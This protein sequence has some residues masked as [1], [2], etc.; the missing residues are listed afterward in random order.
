MH[1]LKFDVILFNINYLGG[2][3]P[4]SIHIHHSRYKGLVNGIQIGVAT[5]LLFS[6]VILMVFCHQKIFRQK[7]LHL[8]EG[9]FLDGGKT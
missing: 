4:D 1:V 5:L 6:L 3:Y 8:E 2:K 9:G 7:L